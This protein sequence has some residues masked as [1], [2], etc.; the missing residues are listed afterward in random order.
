MIFAFRPEATTL[1][2]MLDNPAAK[3]LEFSQ[4]F[5]DRHCYSTFSA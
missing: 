1:T 4:L 3:A 2:R 5:S